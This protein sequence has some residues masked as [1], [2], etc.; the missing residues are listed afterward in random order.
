[1]I[2]PNNPAIDIEA[3]H[4]KVQATAD[5]L[6]ASG[7]VERRRV[8][9]RSILDRCRAA[10]AYADR[11]SAFTQPETRLPRRLRVLERF[12]SAPGILLLRIYNL[13]L[14][15]ARDANTA[16]TQAIREL[17]E[18]GIATS[19]RLAELELELA[20]LRALIEETKKSEP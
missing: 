10:N 8:E 11:A 2:R 15:R 13:A 16:T 6:R 14:R 5:A 12:G 19:Q 17:A 1:V 4:A 9:A 20:R 18:A 7:I 3:L